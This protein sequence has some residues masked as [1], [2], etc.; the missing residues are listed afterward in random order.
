MTSKQAH[1]SEKHP[2]AVVPAP[3]ADPASMQKLLDLAIT[4]GVSV[5]ALEKLVA[6]HER[7][8]DRYAAQQFA[9]DL[10]AFQ[11]DCPPV[12][13]TRV[14]N[15]ATREGGGFSYTYA[16]LD[17]I[18]RTVN[19]LLAARGFSYSWDSVTADEI[20]TVT[21]TLRHANGHS[22]ASSFAAPVE[23]RSK[24][25]SKAQNVS[26]A[27]TFARRQSLISVLGLTTADEDLDGQKAE[28]LH[29]ISDDQATHITDL[30]R[31]TGEKPKR[32]LAWLGVASVAE[33][34]T[35]DYNAA[36]AA[37]EKKRD[38][39]AAEATT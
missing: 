36:V 22:I 13:R 29:A 10:A 20:E 30:L 5:E 7:V 16:P 23:A 32:F 28:Q 11:A 37:L 24:A 33:I 19:P 1:L 14:A 34:S 9:A 2:V 21:C 18:A 3:N 15:I 25:T 27:W 8:A 26:I 12:N 38:E 4:T 31:E 39:K 6:L 17:Q 35:R